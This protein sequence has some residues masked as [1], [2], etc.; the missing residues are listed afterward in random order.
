[1]ISQMVCTFLQKEKNVDFFVQSIFYFEITKIY[2]LH[3][4]DKRITPFSDNFL[5][6]PSE[7]QSMDIE[8]LSKENFCYPKDVNFCI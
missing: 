3:V 1:M 5:I 2:F 4:V 8:V 6:A 7:R